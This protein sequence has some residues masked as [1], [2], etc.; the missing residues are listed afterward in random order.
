M[1]WTTIK[2]TNVIVDNRIVSDEPPTRS[3]IWFQ[4]G[5]RKPSSSRPLRG[6]IFLRLEPDPEKLSIPD[7]NLARGRRETGGSHIGLI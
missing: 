4:V 1:P 7:K 5:K 6:M 3:R 2:T